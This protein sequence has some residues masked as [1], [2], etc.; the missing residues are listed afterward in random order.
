ML[1]N[2]GTLRPNSVDILNMIVT[3]FI[4]TILSTLLGIFIFKNQDIK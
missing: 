3:C 4:L 1:M 2:I